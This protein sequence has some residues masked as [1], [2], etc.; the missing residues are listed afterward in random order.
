MLPVADHPAPGVLD[1]QETRAL[2]KRSCEQV[3]TTFKVMMVA[4]AI[5]ALLS[6]LF[7]ALFT[8]IPMTYLSYELHQIIANFL[9]GLDS[10]ADCERFSTAI[11]NGFTN[12]SRTDVSY[13]S[14]RLTDGAPLLRRSINAYFL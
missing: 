1:S 5:F 13:F 6:P 3:Q 2:I 4:C 10:V 9:V 12:L 7:V 14:S 8:F 11:Q